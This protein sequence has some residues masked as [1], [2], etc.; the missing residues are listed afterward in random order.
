MSAAATMVGGAALAGSPV[1]SQ[2]A[3]AQVPSQDENLT[4]ADE[5]L[6]SGPKVNLLIA[7]VPF[8]FVTAAEEPATLHATSPSP[9]P[10]FARS[11]RLA[12]LAPY[13]KPSSVAP[14]RSRFLPLSPSILPRTCGLTWMRSG[15]HRRPLGQENGQHP[16]DLQA[17]RP[18]LSQGK[19]ISCSRL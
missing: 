12:S 6:V 7:T 17:V 18:D 1:E 19:W 5:F 2:A 13:R 10:P 11:F 16:G 3:T 9:L 14:K 15:A 4:M 8:F